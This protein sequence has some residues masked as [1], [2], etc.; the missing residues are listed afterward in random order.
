[1]R[2]AHRGWQISLWLGLAIAFSP[3][4]L[5]LAEHG[6][7]QPW[8]RV[9]L[10][11]PVLVWIAARRDTVRPGPAAWGWGLVAGGIMLELIVIGGDVVRLGRLGLAGAAI[12]LCFAG[13]WTSLRVA[14]LF[15]WSIPL[16]AAILNRFGPELASV[17]MGFGAQVASRFGLAVVGFPTSLE[18]AGTSLAV[19]PSDCGLQTA[20]VLAGFGCFRGIW[21]R[22]TVPGIRRQAVI[23]ACFAAPLHLILAIAAAL[24]LGLGSPPETIRTGLDDF[25]WLGVSVLA[26]AG[27]FW[28]S[29]TARAGSESSS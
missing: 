9:S 10:V 7:A 20:F 18:S 24:A 8:A 1:V 25:S 21:L 13:G 22:A 14:L 5:E 3:V 4:L 12:G 26:L 17:V 15:L 28:P 11:F 23:G 29:H 2:W 27:V 16:P 6:E 19:L